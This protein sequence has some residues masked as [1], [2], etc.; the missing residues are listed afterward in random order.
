MKPL[1]ERIA[2]GEV[3]V[4][5]GAMGTLLQAR[6]LASGECPES[7]CISRPEVVRSIGE[8][9]TAAGSDILETNSFGGNAVKL[10]RFNLQ[11]KV[12]EFNRT[13]AALAKAAI[14][15]G[16]YVAG[17]VGPTGKLLIEEGGD[18]DTAEFYDAFKQQVEALAE[19]GA[20]LICIETMS[21]LSEAIEAIKAARQNTRLPIVCAF[22]FEARKKG[23]FTMLGVKPERAAKEA[24]AAGADIVGANCGN[25]VDG[26][27]EITRQ[28]RA[29]V[30]DT[31]ILIQPNAGVPELRDGKTL[32]KESAEYMASRV[33]DLVA[34]GA[35]IIGGCCGTTPEHIMAIARS[36]RNSVRV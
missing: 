34:A 33:H 26:M 10:A 25:G 30:P 5:D 28:M 16:G 13:A 14:G 35:N 11:G 3:L 4:S 29:A 17:S 19:G 2:A 23:F 1:I 7:W 9:Y 22:A 24:I 31:P 20:D 36:V 12:R 15:S 8:A 18:A 21:S 6:G 27:I 32:F